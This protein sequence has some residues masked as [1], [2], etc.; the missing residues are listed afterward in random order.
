MCFKADES[1]VNQWLELWF[2]CLC[3]S[4]PGVK[5]PRVSTGM[6]SLLYLTKL[7]STQHRE[8]CVKRYATLHKHAL[9]NVL[10]MNKITTH[11]NS[12]ASGQIRHSLLSSPRSANMKHLVLPSVINLETTGKMTMRNNVRI[13]CKAAINQQTQARYSIVHLPAALRAVNHGATGTNLGSG[14]G[15]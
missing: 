5:P 12:S 1:F 7:H 8:S 13:T 9:A 15:E 11:K 10:Q 3:S 6:Q 14:A 4:P 2:E